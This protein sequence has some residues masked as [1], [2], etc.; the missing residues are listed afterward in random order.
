MM[1]RVVLI[2]KERRRYALLVG[3]NEYANSQDTRPIRPLRFAAGDARDLATLLVQ[4]GGYVPEDV[5]LLVNDQATRE[6]IYTA[7]RSLRSK[8]RE[9]DTVV[10]FFS[11]HGTVGTARDGTSHYYL[12]PY[13]GRINDL[14]RTAIRDDALEELVG[15][16][17]SKKVIFVLDAC[18]SGEIRGNWIKG[19]S[20]PVLHTTPG[21]NSF[22]EGGEGRLRP[23]QR[24]HR[25][26]G[27]SVPFDRSPGLHP[28][29]PRLRAAAGSG[30]AGD[31]RGTHPCRRVV[32]GGG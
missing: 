11:G 17:P 4:N 24:D 31:E 28:A 23:E 25:P 32:T 13:D 22:M 21:R 16:L 7:L 5:Q 1:G 6:A 27:V 18:H 2:L 15:Q 12:V 20:N 3:I 10:I 19:F 29:G 8:V 14:Y 30:G 9:E 26:G